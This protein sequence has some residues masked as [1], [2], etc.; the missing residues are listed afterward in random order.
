MKLTP[1][2][3]TELAAAAEAEAQQAR[4]RGA[5]GEWLTWAELAAVAREAVSYLERREGRS[6]GDGA[7]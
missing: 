4:R 6:E 5:P 7:Q 3:L 1:T 2:L